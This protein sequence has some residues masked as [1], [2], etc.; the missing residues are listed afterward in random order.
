VTSLR[1]GY[2]VPSEQMKRNIAEGKLDD[3][4]REVGEASKQGAPAKCRE[5][6]RKYGVANCGGKYH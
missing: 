6:S 4:L 2:G 3:V 5:I 1:Q